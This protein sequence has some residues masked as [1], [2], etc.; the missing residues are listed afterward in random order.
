MREKKTEKKLM[1]GYVG[2]KFQAVRLSEAAP[3]GAAALYEVFSEACARLRRHDMTPANGGNI[4]I[5]HGDGMVIS[6]SGANLGC[7]EPEELI[8]VTECGED[9]ER[10]CY[11]GPIHPSSESIMHWLIYEDRP[12]AGAIIHA[13]DE[14]ATRPELLEGRVVESKQEEPYGSVALA[15]M[16]IDAFQRAER[17]IV[18]KNHGYVAIGP[19][20]PAARDLVVATHKR[21]LDVSG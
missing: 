10:V 20:L 21:L 8:H 15:R 18:L 14:F 5:R 13:H 12:E 3:P 11:H 1:D 9:D 17:I 7:L 19:D 6:A 16:A 4:S 2:V